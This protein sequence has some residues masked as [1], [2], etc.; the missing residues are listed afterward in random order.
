LPGPGTAKIK[1][2]LKWFTNELAPT[3]E[4]DVMIEDRVRPL[5]HVAGPERGA[6]ALEKEF[7]ARREQAFRRAK[8]FKRS[9][10]AICLDVLEWLETRRIG[11]KDETQASVADFV[12]DLFGR[13]LRKAKFRECTCAYLTAARRMSADDDPLMLGRA[14]SAV[15]LLK[16]RAGLD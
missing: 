14:A 5:R 10:I 13:R 12:D 2:E 1:T 6:R 15:R 9:D 11:S 3:R 4:I 16:R 7:A 8:Q